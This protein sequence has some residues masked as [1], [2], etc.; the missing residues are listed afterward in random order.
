MMFSRK[1]ILLNM[2]SCLAMVLSACSLPTATPGLPAPARSPQLYVSTS[3][4][5]EDDC[6]SEASPCRRETNDCLSEASPCLT[7]H[8]AVGKA[9]PYSVIHIGPGEFLEVGTTYTSKALTLIGAGRDQTFIRHAN[10]PTVFQVNTTAGMVVVRDLTIGSG[11]GHDLS[12]GIE[13]REGAHVLIDNVRVTE[14]VIG[15]R[16]D[17]FATINN[18]VIE[19]N[20]SGIL[21]DGNLEMAGTTLQHN[22]EG[23]VVGRYAGP[24]LWNSGTANITGSTFDHNGYWNSDGI[25]FSQS[26]AI[27]NTGQMNISAST[28]SNNSGQTVFEDGGDLVLDHVAIVLNNTLGIAHA[29][30]HLT[31]RSSIIKDNASDGVFVGGYGDYEGWVKILESAIIGNHGAGLRANVG[32]VTVQNST[33]SGTQTTPGSNSYGIYHTGGNLFLLDSTVAFN[34]GYGVSSSGSGSPVLTM[35]RSVVALND[36]DECSG[37]RSSIHHTNRACDESWTQATLGL[38]P[39]TEEA[40]TWVHPLLPGSPL[41]N[42]AGPPATCPPGDQRGFARP[43]G[44]TC[45]VGAYESGSS[46]AIAPLEFV[47]PSGGATGV[48]PLHTDTPA[49]KTPIILTF[50]KNAFCRK[51]PSALYRDVSGFKQGD[52]AQADGR[53]ET[54]PRWWWVLIPNSNEHC[55]VSHTTVETNDLAEGLPIQTVSLELPQAPSEFVIS[56]RACT[57]KSYSLKLAWTKST[58]AEG[59]VLYRNGE[60]LATF[61]ANQTVYQEN[62]PM[63]QFLLYELEAFNRDGYSERLTVEDNCP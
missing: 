37:V 63:D 38:G 5:D 29:R 23:T 52:T 15:V 18:S 27:Y 45:D 24:A 61:N 22:A 43:I 51:G 33:I 16:N 30:G 40:G 47:T 2:V 19:G 9:E 41:I 54:D 46:T 44:T 56:E 17:G 53:N 26:F 36:G 58:G 35:R 49:P 7:L 42:A 59:Y 48:V 34:Q 57:G 31:V 10:Y 20:A 4:A 55:W 39:L 6:S 13:V 28:F 14:N 3:G 1:N 8:N 11:A 21:N 60:E 32:D 25:T 62:P 50:T 12:I